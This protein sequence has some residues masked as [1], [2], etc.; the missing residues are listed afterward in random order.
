MTTR[1]FWK[2]GDEDVDDPIHPLAVIDII[3]VM[4]PDLLVFFNW[5]VFLIT[6]CFKPTY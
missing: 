6:I 1:G 5:S 2:V 4:L 3:A